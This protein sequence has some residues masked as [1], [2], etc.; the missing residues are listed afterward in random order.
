MAA[1]QLGT[2]GGRFPVSVAAGGNGKAHLV[3]SGDDGKIHYRR[4]NGAAWNPEE[5]LPAPGANNYV[6]FV[7]AP[8]AMPHVVFYSDLGKGS[9]TYTVFYTTRKAKQWS[10]PVRLSNES[11]AQLPR[12]AVSP[13]GGLHVVYNR[14]GDIFEDIYYTSN[15]GAGWSKPE[16]IGKGIAPDLAI[17]AN[18]NVHVA[19]AGE[20]SIFIRV[21]DANGAWSKTTKLGGKQNQSPALVFDAAGNLHF[22]WTKRGEGVFSSLTY[23]RRNSDEALALSKRASGGAVKIALYPRLTL[24]CMNRVHVVYQGKTS[25]EGAEPYR[26]YHRVFDGAT[27]SDL[28]R[29]DVPELAGSSQVPVIHANGS[30]LIASWITGNPSKVYGDVVT[31]E[32]GGTLSAMAPAPVKAKRVAT[33]QKARPSAKKKSMRAPQTRAKRKTRTKKKKG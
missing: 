21:R 27:W 16:M 18:G 13:D 33:K 30:T 2:S 11:F 26:V 4:W 19:W 15:D 25:E 8:N 24:D 14:F 32:C 3:Y 9:P 17:D 31:L 29:L 1:T 5:I 22:A 28:K 23:A 7:T 20:P 10:E 6:P 12:L